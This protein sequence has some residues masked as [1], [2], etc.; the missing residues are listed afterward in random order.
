MDK[1]VKRGLRIEIENAERR[2]R[3]T[4]KKAALKKHCGGTEI[5]NC[6]N[7]QNIL[8]RKDT[9]W[10]DTSHLILCISLICVLFS[11]IKTRRGHI[12]SPLSH[13]CV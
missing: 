12:V 11:P 4:Q 7:I 6:Q 2:W 3:L 10:G 5:L 8:Q 1:T 9:F 13:I